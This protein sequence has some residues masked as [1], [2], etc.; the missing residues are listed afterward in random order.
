MRPFHSS[1][2]TL[3]T[4]VA[5]GLVAALAGALPAGSPMVAATPP[6]GE[7]W[8]TLDVPFD[9]VDAVAVGEQLWIA[10]VADG[11]A[12]FAS[13]DDGGEW[14][15]HDLA[16]LGLPTQNT[17]PPG[18]VMWQLT[19]GSWGGHLYA[20]VAAPPQPGISTDGAGAD[21][22]V[23]T[24]EGAS[25]GGLRLVAPAESGLDQRLPGPGNY[26][27]TALG[28][29]IAGAELP[30]FTAVG[31]FWTPR[32]TSAADFAVIE[33]RDAGQ[34]AISNHEFGDGP[35]E[36]AWGATIGG[37]DIA[38]TTT[39]GANEELATW[40]RTAADWHA[41]RSP[42]PPGID[43][44]DITGAA[45][46]PGRVVAVGVIAAGP[47]LV[48]ARPTAW[49]TVDGVSWSAVELP[50]GATTYNAGVSVAWTGETFVAASTRSGP[51]W[52]SPDGHTWAVVGHGQARR[53]VTWADRVVALDGGLAVSPPLVATRPAAITGDETVHGE[54]TS[55]V[56]DRW[57]F[58]G[59]AGDLATIS[60]IS[61]A[62]DSY[63]E[64]L[65][66]DR[67]LVA[68]DDDSGGGLHARISEVL[69]P[70]TG[71]YTIVAGG[72]SDADSGPY[73]LTLE[74]RSR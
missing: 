25:D 40:T 69:L 28:G 12:V 68:A 49:T 56:R 59:D 23:V 57:T 41:S 47:L 32:A 6:P 19:L 54:L 63:L 30:A 36:P 4:V 61:D 35:F 48:D 33:L 24:T 43:E 13:S 34:W 39:S 26:R 53:L 37:A 74:L 17:F 52:S 21:L 66:P 15:Q 72:Y 55:G 70:A 73:E 1:P 20:L 64:L 51:V 42:L 65:G 29:P 58:D 67:T 46:A 44:A 3:R 2:A 10:R 14:E 18:D 31:Q 22:W 62:F 11:V 27:I 5:V 8:Q 45:S 38:I 16:A 9:P 60:L 50:D 7:V 71:T